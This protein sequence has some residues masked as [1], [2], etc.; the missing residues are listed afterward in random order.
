MK[1]FI[2]FFIVLTLKSSVYAENSSSIMPTELIKNQ[3]KSRKNVEYYKKNI[4]KA[5][6]SSLYRR[7]EYLIYDCVNKHFVCVIESNYERCREPQTKEIVYDTNFCLKIKE[8]ETQPDCFRAH[9]E[10][11]DKTRMK[12]FCKRE[13]ER[14]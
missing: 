6:I 13:K 14:D 2:F 1:Y 10:F 11:S 9:E 8:F 12:F 3:E 7:G 5:V 4:E